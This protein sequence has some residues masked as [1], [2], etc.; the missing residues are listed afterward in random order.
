[1]HFFDDN[2]L[3]TLCNY[4]SSLDPHL[5]QIITTHGHP[6]TWTCKNTFATLILTILEQQVS[7]ASAFASYTRL[8]NKITEITPQK[9]LALSDEEL[10]ACAFTRQKIG[11]TRGL[12]TA[13]IEEKFSLQQ[14]EFEEDEVVRKTLKE[15][16]GIGDW[17]VDIYLIH[18]LRRTD[19]F[20]VGDLALVNAMKEVKQLPPTTTKE[21]LVQIAEAWRPYRSI[22]TMILWHHYLQKRKPKVLL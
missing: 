3:L 16:K 22:A 20:P 19:I 2:N 13:L 17:T 11:Y 12:A 10:R 4:L 5:N 15:L 18:A 21:E 8:L 9:L 14:F 6:P 7:L 1:M